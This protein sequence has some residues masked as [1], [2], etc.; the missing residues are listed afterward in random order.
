[1]VGDVLHYNQRTASDR[2]YRIDTGN[3]ASP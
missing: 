1:M 3:L 2:I